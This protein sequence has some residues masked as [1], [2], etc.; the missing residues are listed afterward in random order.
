MR[1]CAASGGRSSRTTTSRGWWAR[2]G[3]S[4][5]PDTPTRA[6]ARPREGI[7]TMHRNESL[8]GRRYLRLAAMGLALAAVSTACGS[9]KSDTASAGTTASPGTTAAADAAFQQVIDAAKKE[10]SVTIY[11]SQ[12]LD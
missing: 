7:R 9:S 10:G 3:G 4:S 5:D 12:G 1:P 11:S 8:R 2:H 6:E